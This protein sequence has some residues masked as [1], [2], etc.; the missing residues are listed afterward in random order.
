[1]QEFLFCQT[2]AVFVNQ[3]MPFNFFI[4]QEIITLLK[5]F[6]FAFTF[7]FVTWQIR[8]T[9]QYLDGRREL[10]HYVHSGMSENQL[11]VIRRGGDDDDTE[12]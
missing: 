6:I 2:P 8:K 10:H 5:L 3:K 12:M 1:V 9:A 7:C 11:P 4:S